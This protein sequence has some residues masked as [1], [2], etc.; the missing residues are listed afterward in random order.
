[1]EPLREAT[2][3]VLQLGSYRC[4]RSPRSQRTLEKGAESHHPCAEAEEHH[5]LQAVKGESLQV[6]QTKNQSTLEVSC[7]KTVLT[8]RWEATGKGMTILAS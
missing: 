4:K 7:Y 6:T 5:Q 8:V 2:G 1:M 3:N